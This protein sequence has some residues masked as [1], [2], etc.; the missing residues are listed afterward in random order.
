[1]TDTPA[2]TITKILTEILIDIL[3]ETLT[4]ML[5]QTLTNPMHTST[6]TLAEILKG[7]LK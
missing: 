7:T 2:E 3:A 1:M 6:E 5:G 4:N